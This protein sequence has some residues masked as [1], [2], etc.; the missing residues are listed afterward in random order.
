MR[1]GDL[2]KFKPHLRPDWDYQHGAFLVLHASGSFIELHGQR[3][4][5]WTARDNF[6]LVSKAHEHR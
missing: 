6:I 5:G 3:E 2:V 1:I 4:Y